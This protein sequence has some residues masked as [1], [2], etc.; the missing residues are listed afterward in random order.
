MRLYTC[1]V[2]S[3][4][5]LVT[6]CSDSG[7]DNV[8]DSGFRNLPENQLVRFRDAQLENF[9]FSEQVDYMEWRQVL[10]NATD[11]EPRVVAE[12][13]LDIKQRFSESQLLNLENAVTNTGVGLQCLPAACVNYFVTVQ[14]EMVTVIDNFLDI[15]ALI[16]ELDT[17]AEIH[18]VLIPTDF[19]A[20][21]YREIAGGFQV[22]AVLNKC[23]GNIVR[24]LLEIDRSG[25]VTEL[26]IVSEVATNVVC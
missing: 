26:G 8:L 23:S 14:G 15:L 5:T 7:D 18:L 21:L 6:A 9:N 24:Y 12:Y 3:L 20:E 19:S 13:D 1:L 17:P 11:Q 10:I 25:N 16:G 22:V 4:L 2:I